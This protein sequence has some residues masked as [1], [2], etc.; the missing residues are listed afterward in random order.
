ME[1]RALCLLG[2]HFT[3]EPHSQLPLIT[4]TVLPFCPCPLH[5]L[6]SISCQRDLVG[7]VY[8]LWM[9]Q[10]LLFPFRKIPTAV[11]ERWGMGGFQPEWQAQK[12]QE[13]VT[14]S[15][16]WSKHE[17][18]WAC[19]GILHAK[20]IVQHWEWDRGVAIQH[21]FPFKPLL[22]FGCLD[23]DTIS[24]MFTSYFATFGFRSQCFL[25]LS[26]TWNI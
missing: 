9:L 20:I 3:T 12:N 15:L 22:C 1:P 7:L 14:G 2:K 13:R 10:G 21:I 6:Y 26:L 25:L 11:I 23:L 4:F 16:H 24:K 19:K 5:H 17:S 8:S 18:E